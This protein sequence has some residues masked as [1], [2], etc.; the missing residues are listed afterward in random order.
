MNARDINPIT[1]NSLS[2]LTLRKSRKK[3][4]NFSLRIVG[5]PKLLENNLREAKRKAPASKDKA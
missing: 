4:A 3:I 2:L 5:N 1:R